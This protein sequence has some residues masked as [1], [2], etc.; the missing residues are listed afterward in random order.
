MSGS[1]GTA[2]VSGGAALLQMTLRAA[3]L[4]DFLLSLRSAW[5]EAASATSDAA[6]ARLTQCYR[7]VITGAV[8]PDTIASTI[9][10]VSCLAPPVC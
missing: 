3:R 4:S 9:Q 1:D 7:A 10:S 6:I 5:P 2:T 8:S